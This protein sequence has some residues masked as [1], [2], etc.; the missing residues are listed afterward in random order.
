M[1]LCDYKPLHVRSYKE[2]GNIKRAALAG[3]AQRNIHS[4]IEV[5]DQGR[6]LGISRRRKEYH[7]RQSPTC[8]S[9]GA[10][11]SSVWPSAPRGPLATTF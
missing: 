3:D 7:R 10:R 4:V 1:E 2:K 8:A 6:E 11:L 5:I 9:Q